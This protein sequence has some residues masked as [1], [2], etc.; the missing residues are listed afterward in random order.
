MAE[1]LYRLLYRSRPAIDGPDEER[2]RQLALILAASRRRNPALEVTGV[3]MLQ[4]GCFVQALE[5][6]MRAIEAVFELICRDERH[7]AVTLIELAPIDARSFIDWA[8]AWID[9]A[10]AAPRPAPG[11]AADQR[12]PQECLA[13]MLAG[14]ASQVRN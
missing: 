14:L 7:G 9:A 1:P 13:A 10:A 12:T 6:P 2:Q 3:L 5:G 8:M 4:D 11:A